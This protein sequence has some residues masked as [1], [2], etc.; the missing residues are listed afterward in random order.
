[1]VSVTE[2]ML[3][4]RFRAGSARLILQLAVFVTG[5]TASRGAVVPGPTRVARPGPTLTA[6]PTPAQPEPAPESPVPVDADDAQWGDADAPVT[7]VEF[8]DLE[9]PFCAR[10]Q[11]TVTEL[12]RRYGPHQLRVAFKHYPLPFH[13]HARGAAQAARAVL[14]LRGSDAFFGYIDTLFR[15]QTHLEPDQLERAALAF[16][17]DPAAF[18]AR[19]GS[20]ELSDRIEADR[21]LAERLGIDGTPHFLINGIHVSGAVPLGELAAPIDR[22]L[23]RAAELREHG[24]A[25][26]EISA[27]LTRDNFR[28][29]PPD[30]GEEP[31]DTTVWNVPLGDSPRLG[32]DDALVTIIEFAD[33]E[34]PFCQRVQLTLATLRE[35]Y[36]A[37]VRI[38]FKHLPLPFHPRARPS[39][40]LA[41]EARKKLGDAG[42]WKAV[43]FLFGSSPNLADSDL[44]PI[45]R[46]L[47]LDWPGVRNAAA[48][49]ADAAILDADAALARDFGAAGVPHFFINGRRLV[50]AQPL[51]AFTASV[52]AALAEARQLMQT[53]SV[54]RKLV[55]SE[56]MRTARVPPHQ[57]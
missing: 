12:E 29:P 8:S 7:L 6:E 3:P 42:F 35:Q 18:A 41:I 39:A 55:F 9:C 21:T 48:H 1:M 11:P 28:A 33:F 36:G 20:R 4:T 23:G 40:T 19:V 37:D 51:E 22:E 2:L 32:P 44:E 31:E 45:A 57:D 15:D 47:G 56:L 10:A 49:D 13:R 24:V 26:R 30:L 43:G 52:D 17:V 38:V 54:P 46:H 27:R 53:K 5:C 16:G 50:G 25:A 14:E 34:C